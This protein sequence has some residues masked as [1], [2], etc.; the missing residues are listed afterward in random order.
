MEG[1]AKGHVLLHSSHQYHSQPTSGSKGAITAQFGPVSRESFANLFIAQ[2]GFQ[3]GTFP[4][5]A[6]QARHHTRATNMAIVFF[7]FILCYGVFRFIGACFIV[8]VLLLWP[9][10]V[11]G[12]PLYFCTVIP[13]YLSSFFPRLISAVGDWMSTILPHMVWP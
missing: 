7:V 3:A 10:I 12:R 11:I 13:F 1:H 8:V 4:S 6:F 9:P 2:C 5:I